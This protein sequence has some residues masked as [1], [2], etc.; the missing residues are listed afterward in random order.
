LHASGYTDKEIREMMLFAGFVMTDTFLEQ[1]VSSPEFV[2]QTMDLPFPGSVPY[3]KVISRTTYE[4]PNKQI[5]MSPQEYQHKHLERIGS[6][7]RYEI[8]DGTHFIYANN[9]ERI[10]EIAEELLG[11]P[12][13]P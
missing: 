1:M 4:T 6:H 9:V 11:L 13:R 7:A 3:Y 2:K 8:L 10:A 5:D 12:P